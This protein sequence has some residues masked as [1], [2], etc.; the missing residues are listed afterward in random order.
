[1]CREIREELGCEIED[2]RLLDVLENRY[3]YEG[4]KGREI[5]FLYK[6]ELADKSMCERNPVH[7]IEDT[8]EF[9][10]D[11]VTVDDILGGK[12]KLYPTCDYGKYLKIS[13]V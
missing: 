5:V 7:I 13:K 9:Y 10:A 4:Q 11:W 1:M 3:T 6:G 12:K 8:Y 2:L